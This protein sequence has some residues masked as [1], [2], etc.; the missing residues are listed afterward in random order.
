[1][2]KQTYLALVAMF[3]FTVAT[4]RSDY[5]D[6]ELEY[7]VSDYTVTE[8]VG[9]DA[10]TYLWVE[11]TGA[12]TDGAPGEPCMPRIAYD[13]VVP[14]GSTNVYAEVI[15][16]VYSEDEAAG[17]LFYPGQMPKGTDTTWE[18]TDPGGVYEDDAF[19]PGQELDGY[20]KGLWRGHFASQCTLA[21]VQYNPV[22]G[23]Y[24]TLESATLRINYSPPLSAPTA[25][26]WEWEHVYDRWSDYLKTFVLNPEDVYDN[27][28]PVDFVDTIAYDE[29]EE[30]G[31]TVTVAANQ[32]S[33]FYSSY[34]PVADDEEWPEEGTSFAYQYIIITNDW[35]RHK[36][37]NPDQINLTSALD[38]LVDWKTEKGVPVIYKTVDDIKVHDDYKQQGN[39][40]W[41]WQVAVRRFLKAA[42]KYWGP[43]Y[44]FFVGDVDKIDDSEWSP[45]WGQYGVVPI[46][47]F[48]IGD[49]S[50]EVYPYTDYPG[51]WTAVA[52]TDLYYTDLNIEGDW[53]V[54][55]DNIFGEPTHDNVKNFKPDVACGWLPASNTD[56]VE[57]YISKVLKYEKNPDLTKT[58]GHTYMGRFLHIV[59]DEGFDPFYKVESIPDLLAG[60]DK[61]LMYEVP[62]AGG[63][64]A[65]DFPT[66]PQ[67][68]DIND[69]IDNTGFGIIGIDVHGHPYF[70]Y[71]LTQGENDTRGQVW[72]SH[73]GRTSHYIN[74]TVYTDT[75]EDL[76][77]DYY[78][79][80]VSASCKTNCFEYDLPNEA[81]IVSERYLF[82]AD[83][84]GVAY[85]G[86]TRDGSWFSSPK[87]EKEFYRTL[88]AETSA[89]SDDNYF[90]G[91]AETWGKARYLAKNKAAPGNYWYA[92]THILSGDPELNVWTA[93]PGELDLD[94]SV[95]EGS[96][97]NY[98]IKV[99]VKDKA[100]NNPVY[101]ANVCL[102]AP[103]E[104]YLLNLSNENGRCDFVVPEEASGKITATKHNW[105]PAW[106]SFVAE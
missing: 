80:I 70:H 60:F 14:F 63:G 77:N 3:A 36:T 40:Y 45:D 9:D 91:P 105:V 15:D 79:I 24:K 52:T 73:P 84:G 75:I 90:L 32:E 13:A 103:G 20:G 67:P 48:A 72:A 31:Y 6:F 54:E 78:G 82:D 98:N 30:S 33:E 18:W 44:V 86:N 57:D 55:P 53:D 95:Q 58:G 7:D 62:R 104:A 68:H 37:G 69:A 88:L 26:R 51:S 47:A 106:E 12:V 28:E 85:L 27:R 61:T 38:D 29:Y 42:A 22:D 19:F 56:E 5:I 43:E 76:D 97:G 1:M 23:V 99:T 66:Y 50:P 96:G 83:G 16:A 8:I 21:P 25:E 100:T 81:D 49:H 59:T 35:A 93:D 64:R 39:E 41:D 10:E 92:Y 65:G 89:T 74:N 102:H 71:V 17:Y 87:V 34:V 101:L 11:V 94:V 2:K 4:V 46:R